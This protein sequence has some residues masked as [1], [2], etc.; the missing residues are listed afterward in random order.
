MYKIYLDPK[1]KNHPYLVVKGKMGCWFSKRE[2]QD[3][4]YNTWAHDCRPENMVRCERLTFIGEYEDLDALKMIV[5]LE[6]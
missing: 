6:E 3:N 2:I 4:L 5:L 1:D